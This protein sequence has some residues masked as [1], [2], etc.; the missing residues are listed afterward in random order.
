MAQSASSR[1]PYTRF[2]PV[3]PNSSRYNA[4]LSK[5]ERAMLGPR[6]RLLQEQ[7]SSRHDM[8]LEVRSLIGRPVTLAQLDGLLKE[9]NICFYKQPQCP[10]A[11]NT[12]R[13]DAPLS[14]GD[15]ATPTHGCTSP[16]V[17]GHK[18]GLEA[19]NRP[20][21]PESKPPPTDCVHLRFEDVFMVDSEQSHGQPKEHRDYE[22]IAARSAIDSG[23]SQSE[24]TGLATEAAE[25]GVQFLSG[26]K[27]VIQSLD[28][29]LI[30][31]TRRLH[32]PQGPE[33]VV[34]SSAV[35]IVSA[36]LPSTYRLSRTAFDL[37]TT[38]MLGTQ[39]SMDRA[40]K[41]KNMATIIFILRDFTEAFNLYFLIY[42]HFRENKKTVDS[43]HPRMVLGAIN[44]ARS[45]STTVQKQIVSMLIEDVRSTLLQQYPLPSMH[46]VRTWKYLE[47]VE[48]Q[49]IHEN[50]GTLTIALLESHEDLAYWAVTAMHLSN[51]KLNKDCGGAPGCCMTL[52]QGQ[53]MEHLREC[54]TTRRCF[55]FAVDKV[56]SYIKRNSH[57]FD[58]PFREDSIQRGDYNAQEVACSIL[59]ECLADR[60]AYP[61]G[62]N[63]SESDNHR[64]LPCDLNGLAV[65]V[66]PFLL[67]PILIGRRNLEM[68]LFPSASDPL[69]SDLLRCSIQDI[70]Q[71]IEYPPRYNAMIES[72][73]D[74]FSPKFNPR[75]LHTSNIPD[76]RLRRITMGIASILPISGTMTETDVEEGWNTLKVQQT[77]SAVQAFPL[78][79][80]TTLAH[81]LPTLAQS[82]TSSTSS[83][84]RRFRTTA[85]RARPG[86]A[87]SI[88]SQQTGSSSQRSQNSSLRFS[89]VTGLPS[90]PSS[91]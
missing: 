85:F 48:R 83:D 87:A 84:Y 31:A 65:A 69:L 50:T 56:K 90:N 59:E 76:S 22:M 23:T 77:A 15:N 30:F 64:G 57:M 88:A 53:I 1:E 3:E 86:T 55:R 80:K 4:R 61:V 74:H 25:H 60:A 34:S 21:S 63:H 2:I 11:L 35:G 43:A 18:S 20:E 27:T 37:Y 81:G 36:P 72:I 24:P 9:H 41:L 5:A 28:S 52:G 49:C 26:C 14:Q 12:S 67:E 39:D 6:L 62:S 68:E 78:R 29:S 71:G 16:S 32:G 51:D 38:T 44:C 46:D 7:G 70:R 40:A 82:F 73:I 42:F 45:A 17:S 79:E 58:Q 19:S 47:A 13:S 75:F 54:E 8:Q 66:I 91:P 33:M 10:V 89:R